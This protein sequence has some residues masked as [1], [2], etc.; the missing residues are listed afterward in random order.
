M[1]PLT[2]T[3]LLLL[4]PAQGDLCTEHGAFA[5]DSVTGQ[6]MRC[7]HYPGGGQTL[8]WERAQ[9]LMDLP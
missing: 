9:S 6:G 2:L 3:L 7:A 5:Q 1:I 8:R 4:S